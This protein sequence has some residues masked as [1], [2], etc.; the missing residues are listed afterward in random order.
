MQLHDQN[1]RRDDYWRRGVCKNA[2][3]SVNNQ[4]LL[5]LEITDTA[6]FAVTGIQ[7]S[8]CIPQ[9]STH[10][11]DEDH[12]TLLI[13][14]ARTG[15]SANVVHLALR[16]G[17]SIRYWRRVARELQKHGYGVTYDRGKTFHINNEGVNEAKRLIVEQRLA[18]AEAATAVAAAANVSPPPPDACCKRCNNSLRPAARYCSRCGLHVHE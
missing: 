8:M 2:I 5:A 1:P 10:M 18:E 11:L 9:R 4:A 3:K 6:R 16:S 14:A 15:S 7:T 13:A 12:E 17:V